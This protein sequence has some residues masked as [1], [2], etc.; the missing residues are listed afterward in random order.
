MVAS[1]AAPADPELDRLLEAY[2]HTWDD[3]GVVRPLALPATWQR[4]D[5]ARAALL[6]Y[7]AANY[8]R[9]ELI[10]DDGPFYDDGPWDLLPGEEQG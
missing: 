5:A 3:L 4:I 1:P 7:L 10:S 2:D 6:D 8:V 9:C